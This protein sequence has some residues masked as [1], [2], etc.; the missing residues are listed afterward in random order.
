MKLNNH[1]KLSNEDLSLVFH[2][3]LNNIIEVSEV[4]NFLEF[5]NSKTDLYEEI[6]ILR[7]VIYNTV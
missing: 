5:L 6:K 2:N 1:Q 3:I 7:E 4:I